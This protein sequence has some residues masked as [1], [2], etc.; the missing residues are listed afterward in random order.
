MPTSPV[1]GLNHK[2]QGTSHSLQSCRVCGSGT[3]VPCRHLQGRLVPSSLCKQQGTLSVEATSK[4]TRPTNGMA[5][6]PAAMNGC[7][8]T[9]APHEDSHHCSEPG[10][11]SVP[12]WSVNVHERDTEQSRV[13][14]TEQG[15]Q[16]RI[17][18][19]A[20]VE[21]SRGT[22]S[23][24]GVLSAI[25]AKQTG[26]TKYFQKKH[27][28]WLTGW[29]EF[30]AAFMAVF[31]LPLISVVPFSTTTERPDSRAWEP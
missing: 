28:P 12:L 30:S 18:G 11:L 27:L 22:A 16:G 10:K 13:L 19:S 7:N 25:S 8:S 31:L 2:P 17:E 5:P 15:T 26:N 3:S 24:G 29:W 1:V 4:T 9:G 23:G 14:M 6:H 21:A 20:L